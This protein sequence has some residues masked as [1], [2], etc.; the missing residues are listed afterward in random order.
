MMIDTFKP[1]P[2]TSAPRVQDAATAPARTADG[3]RAQVEQRAETAQAVARRIE[4][5][6]R[7]SGRE[8]D[9][10]VDV[11]TKR[12][13]VT[14]RDP[15]TGEVIRQIPSEEVLRIA[16]SLSGAIER[17]ADFRA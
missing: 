16:R 9:F 14:V 3:P 2:A 4:Q 1:Q 8:L 5:Y 12:M 15:T 7:E 10:H 11:D 6:L 13:V 17:L